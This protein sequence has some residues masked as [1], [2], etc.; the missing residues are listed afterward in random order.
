[1]PLPYPHIVEKV[2]EKIVVV[3]ERIGLA[4][5]VGFVWEVIRR[6]MLPKMIPPLLWGIHCGCLGV[7]TGE[8]ILYSMLKLRDANV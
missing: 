1:M 6:T 5:E 8:C 2:I 7:T 3:K 4:C